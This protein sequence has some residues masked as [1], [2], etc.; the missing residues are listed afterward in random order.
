VP[1]YLFHVRKSVGFVQDEEG[2][3]LADLDAA[4]GYAVDSIRSMVSGDARGGTID[5]DGSIEIEGGEGGDASVA[6]AEAFRL[7]LPEPPEG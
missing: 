2:E 5:L 3:T 1:H 4:R 7:V 6:Y